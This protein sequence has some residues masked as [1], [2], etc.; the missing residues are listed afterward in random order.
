M[1][2]SNN[3]NSGAAIVMVLFM[4]A[5]YML[6][7]IAAIF[8]SAMAILFTVL[9]IMAWRQPIRFVNDTITPQEAHA[10][11]RRGLMGAWIAPLLI[12]VGGLA[13]EIAINWDYVLFYIWGGY[14]AGSVGMVLLLGEQSD[15]G[16]PLVE[17]LPPQPEPS[18]R[19]APQSLPAPPREPFRFASWDDGER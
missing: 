19:S 10:F 13:I 17:Y 8:V 15:P 6:L 5:A 2:S 16:R 7:I 4:L 14:C 1:A 12:G 11:V 3:D 18:S 9:S